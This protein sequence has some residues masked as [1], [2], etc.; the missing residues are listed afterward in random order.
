MKVIRSRILGFCKGVRRAVDM[1]VKASSSE[2]LVYTLGPLI[3]NS[4]VLESLEKQ[5][6][7]CLKEAEFPPENSTVIIRAH[8]VSPLV[9]KKLALS[10]SIIDATCPRVKVSQ[11][12]AK[13]FAEKGYWVFLA[14][15]A[16]HAEIDGIRGYAEE[17]SSAFSSARCFVVSNPAEA[18][19]AAV[20]LHR[21]EPEAKTALIGQTTI[22]AGEYGLIG[23]K[24]RQFFSYLEIADSVCEAA[25][26]RQKALCELC[27]KVDAV[28][29]AGSRESANTLRLLSLAKELGK[30]AWLAEISGDLPA[31]IKNYETLGLSAGAS[32]PESLIDEI[33][34]VLI[35][36][37]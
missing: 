29:I 36:K 27:A 5:G 25:G 34:K 9:E 22:R 23:E 16:N 32:T 24:I 26:D 17:G 10:C 7:V 4:R 37:W 33:E 2:G 12:R 30:P 6:V 20:E 3:H 19:A 35:S 8:G 14:G 13:E 15:E 18:E 1:A 28:I 11:K 21:L 31:E